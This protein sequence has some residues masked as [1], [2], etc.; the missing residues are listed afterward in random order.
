ML[1]SAGCAEALT[2]L[3]F[4]L[5]GRRLVEECPSMSWLLIDADSDNVRA[6]LTSLQNSKLNNRSNGDPRTIL[7]FVIGR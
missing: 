3:R 1:C 5:L 4:A 7:L 6:I 2:D